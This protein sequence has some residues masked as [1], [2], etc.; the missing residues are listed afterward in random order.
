MGIGEGAGA[1]ELEEGM[2]PVSLEKH[3]APWRG[4]AGGLGGAK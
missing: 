4:T 2:V 3:K 1:G